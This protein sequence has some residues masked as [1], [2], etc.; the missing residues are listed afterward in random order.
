MAETGPERTYDVVVIGAGPP[1]ENVAGRVRRGGLTCAIVESR[2][3]G[4]ECSFYACIPSKAMLR[5]VNLAAATRR[6]RGVE[7]SGLDA[8]EVFA[9]RNYWTSSWDDTGATGWLDSEGI[10]LVR[11]HGRLAGVRRVEVEAPDGDPVVLVARHAVVLSTGTL[12]AVPPDPGAARGQAVDQHRGHQA[13]S[14]CPAGWSSWAAA[15]WPAR[16]RRRTPGSGSTV[17]LVE[18]AD[19]AARPQRAVRRRDGRRRAARG[20]RRRPA[21]RPR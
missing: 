12:A 2:L 19:A 18:R 7:P 5:P 17:T 16:W 21:R 13:P 10:D 11:G 8:A 6:V 1:G 9:R 20:G 4:G 15:W 14:R 3:V